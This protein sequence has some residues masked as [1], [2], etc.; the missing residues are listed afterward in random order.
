[1]LELRFLHLPQ[2][3]TNKDFSRFKMKI[4]QEKISQKTI[5][6]SKYAIRRYPGVSSYGIIKDRSG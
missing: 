6:G 4:T 5:M 3:A 2:S 1:M